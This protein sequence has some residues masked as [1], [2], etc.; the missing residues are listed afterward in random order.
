MLTGVDIYSSRIDDELWEFDVSGSSESD[1][2]Q[3]TNIEGLSPVAVDISTSKSATG[4]GE[5]K[6]GTFRGK[7]NLVFTL[8]SNPDWDLTDIST[9]FHETLRAKLYLAFVTGTE[10]RMVF[11]TDGVGTPFHDVEIR[12]TVE[13]LEYDIFS[14]DPTYQLSV[15]CEDPDFISTNESGGFLVPTVAISAY[16]GF[17]HDFTYED[18]GNEATGF[19]VSVE[20]NTADYTGDVYIIASDP[21][22]DIMVIKDVTID[23]VS[24]LEVS[25]VSGNKYA[26]MVYTDGRPTK[27]V[28]GQVTGASRW[29]KL[30]PETISFTVYTTATGS[31]YRMS[32]YPRYGGL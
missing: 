24:K 29:P 17:F 27:S 18:N 26:R 8:A 13:S 28:V 14:Q 20:R 5:K 19:K 16:P 11:S 31:G 22:D 32:Y 2:I 25:T 3:I 4:S 23:A 1:P 30:T 9:S 15:I 10:I 7:R 21:F 6:I 12:G